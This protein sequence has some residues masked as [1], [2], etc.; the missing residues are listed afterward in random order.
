MAIVSGDLKFY[1]TGGA[2][3][4][5]PALSLGG[6]ISSVL[7]TDATLQNL[8]ANVSPADA[9]AGCTHYRALS[10]KNT[11]ALTAYGA[12]V[13]ISLET[14]SVD[15]TVAIAY[16]STGTQSIVNEDTAPTG[17]SFS[18]PLSLGAGIALGDVAASGVRRIWFRR[19]VSPGAVAA[20]D[21]G[22]I[23]CTVGSA[24]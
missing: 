18:T 22:K 12:V 3:N 15:T 6:V 1:L 4:A 13:Y 19:I 23:T 8:F 24:P 9:L 2:A 16:D 7:F 11:S 17:V 21:S 5:D 14:T 20:S 10:F